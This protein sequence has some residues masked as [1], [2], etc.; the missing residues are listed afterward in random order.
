VSKNKV[1]QPN[2]KASFLLPKY[3]LTWLSVFILYSISWLPYKLQLFLG[4]MLGRIFLKIG[5][6][7]K[8]VALRNLELC[9]PEMS[10]AQRQN[11]LTKNFENTGIPYLK[12]AWAGGGQNGVLK[13]K[14]K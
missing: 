9:F 10:D 14:L 2:F 7:R 8:K 11:M 3:W 12:P 1:L 5:G 4:R 13:E 6:S